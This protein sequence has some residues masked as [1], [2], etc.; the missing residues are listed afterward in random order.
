MVLNDP[1]SGIFSYKLTKSRGNLGML[2]HTAK[3]SDRKFYDC[4]HLKKLSL[5]Q[6]LQKLRTAI[7]QVEAGNSSKI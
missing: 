4:L 1:K 7:A 3:V 2:A 5:G 6:L